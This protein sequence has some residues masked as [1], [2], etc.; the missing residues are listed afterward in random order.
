MQEKDRFVVILANPPFG[1][2][3]RADVRQNFPIRTGETAFLFLQHFI[4]DPK[5]AK[6]HPLGKHVT[7]S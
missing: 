5:A 3:Q 7:T 6:M 2:K 1:G 4:N